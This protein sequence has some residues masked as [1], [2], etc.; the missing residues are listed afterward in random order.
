[1]SS[2]HSTTPADPISRAK[3]EIAEAEGDVDLVT[4]EVTRP[5]EPDEGGE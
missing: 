4:G 5:P 3:E 2:T 1:M